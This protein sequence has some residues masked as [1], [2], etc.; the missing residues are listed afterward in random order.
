[1]W[2]QEQVRRTVSPVSRRFASTLQI[3]SLDDQ[4]ALTTWWRKRMWARMPF[5]R[6]V[7]ST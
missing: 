3:A 4:A 6:A 2:S 1:M 5:S 7:S